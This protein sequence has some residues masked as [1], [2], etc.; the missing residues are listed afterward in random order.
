[1]IVIPIESAYRHEL[2][3]SS[4]LSLQNAVFAADGSLQ[5]QTAVGPELPLG[6]EAMRGLNESD[7]QSCSDRTNR[8]NLAQ[9]I[10][11]VVLLALHQQIASDLLTKNLQCVELPIAEIRPGAYAGF[12]DLGQPFVPM[13]WRVDS[14]SRAGNRPTSVES[15][16]P[17]H[18]PRE[19]LGDRQVAAGQ[20]FQ[21]PHAVLSVVNR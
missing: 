20:F 14:L 7:Q 15:F 9:Q 11:R 10:R 5:S 17:V 12:S 4:E 13:A 1:M 18:H 2:L 16:E 3:G 21:G 6:A 19:I 8:R